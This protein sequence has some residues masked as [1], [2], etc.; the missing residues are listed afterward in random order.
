M[1]IIDIVKKMRYFSLALSYLIEEPVRKDIKARSSYIYIDLDAET[2]KS[3]LPTP[4]R[5][6]PSKVAP[7]IDEFQGDSFRILVDGKFLPEINSSRGY[8]Q[9]GYSLD[10][11]DQ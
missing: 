9:N 3:D 8:V 4:M 2:V 1:N 6:L 11:I 7:V 10:T 5:S